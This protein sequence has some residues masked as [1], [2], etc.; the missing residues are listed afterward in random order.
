MLPFLVD[1]TCCC[2]LYSTRVVAGTSLLQT[3][4][5]I[6]GAMSMSHL[7]LLDSCN[8]RPSSTVVVRREW[9]WK[10]PPPPHHS[11][12]PVFSKTGMK[13]CLKVELHKKGGVTLDLSFPKLGWNT[14]WRCSFTRRVVSHWTCLFQ[15]WYETLF[16]GRASQEGWCHI[17]PVFSKNGMKHW[18]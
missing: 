8:C 18:R 1:G 17:G 16:E 9:L 6:V 2:C 12:G 5:V 7:L 11:P 13:H 4:L 15:K 3:E 10:P 14:V